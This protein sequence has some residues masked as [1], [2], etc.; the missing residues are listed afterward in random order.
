LVVDGESDVVL[1]ASIRQ[2]ASSKAMAD[3][4]TA[5]GIGLNLVQIVTLSINLA[6]RIW[7]FTDARSAL[8]QHLETIKQR[9]DI[10]SFTLKDI[11]T[12]GFSEEAVQ[13]LT[14]FLESIDKKLQ[15]FQKML[16]EYLPETGASTMERLKKGFASLGKDSRVKEFADELSGDVDHL[17]LFLM[18]Q[19]INQPKSNLTG[20]LGGHSI[21]QVARRGVAKFVG[22]EDHMAALDTALNE[23]PH[24]AMLQ[25]MGGQG[26]TQIALEYCRRSRVAKGYRAIFWANASSEAALRE[27]FE[28]F[29]DVLK[30][31]DDNSLVD[32]DARV[33][34]T[35]RV[36][37]DWPAPWLLVLDNFDDPSKFS[38]RNYMPVSMQ[39]RI[40]ITTRAREVGKLGTHIPVAGMSDWEALDLL[41]SSGGLDRSDE[42]NIV[43]GAKIVNRLGNMPLAIDLA[44]SYLSNRAGMV[45]IN[46]FLDR[47][48]KQAEA[49][50]QVVPGV[51][52]YANDLK[53]SDTS[54]FATWELTANLL[55]PDT[56]RGGQMLTF[57]NILGFFNCESIS[58]D[59]FRT[60]HSKKRGTDEL[61]PWFSLFTD[62]SGDWSSTA[63][64]DLVAHLGSI[65][66]VEK[67]GRN[68]AGLVQ[69]S[70]HP[71]IS[72]WLRI[73]QTRDVESRARGLENHQLSA[74]MLA[75]CLSATYLE[76][77]LQPAFKMPFKE[78]NALT[79][80]L[81][82]R[83]GL[84]DVFRAR[85]QQPMFLDA[86]EPIQCVELI[87]VMYFYDIGVPSGLPIAER[88]WRDCS[89]INEQH[90]AVK[91]AAGAYIWHNLCTVLNHTEAEK[92]SREMADFWARTLGPTHPFTLEAL[93]YAAASLS[94][95]GAM[96]EAEKIYRDIVQHESDEWRQLC[97]DNVWF[98]RLEWS[99]VEL[100][101]VLGAQRSEAKKAEAAIITKQVLERRVLDGP[102]V[103]HG[104]TEWAWRCY[105]MMVKTCT[106]EGSGIALELLTR[107]ERAWGRM[108]GNYFLA[109]I[110]VMEALLD[111]ESP[112]AQERIL[113][114]LLQ[115]AEQT[116]DQQSAQGYRFLL[117]GLQSLSRMLLD[118]NR[119]EDAE[120]TLRQMLAVYEDLP[121]VQSARNAVLADL[122]RC[123]HRQGR[124][125]AADEVLAQIVSP[126]LD[127][128]ILHSLVKFKIGLT[129][130]LDEASV[131][132]DKALEYFLIPPEEPSEDE[133]AGGGSFSLEM[134][135]T[136]AEDSALGD[137]HKPKY[138]LDVNGSVSIEVLV[139]RGL[140]RLRLGD[141]PGGH[142]NLKE[143]EDVF[144]EGGT[145][146][147][148]L[149]SEFCAFIADR[150]QELIDFLQSPDGAPLVDE[151]TDKLVSLLDWAIERAAT[152]HVPEDRK[153]ELL[154][155]LHL[156]RQEIQD[157]A[158]LLVVTNDNLSSLTLVGSGSSNEKKTKLARFA[159]AFLNSAKNA[160]NNNNNKPASFESDAVTLIPSRTSTIKVPPVSLSSQLSSPEKEEPS[161]R[162]KSVDASL[163]EP[164]YH[165]PG[166]MPSS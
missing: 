139:L 20:H 25:G 153:E 123:L 57:L 65:S 85:Q 120:R 133:G 74:K 46:D 27:S 40:I 28:S 16:D 32:A 30:A 29:S 146:A 129:E 75:A 143:A 13:S 56:E 104:S 148:G 83:E 144:S 43:Q 110:T 115:S 76:F 90:R 86:S 107:I 82:T 121:D 48:S 91:R 96:D 102:L 77:L 41:L 24:V 8:P 118:R 155:R 99:L 34:F 18:T 116:G 122:G 113:K 84:D 147:D 49:V 17:T 149:T 33:A 106:K 81:L 52:E 92:K 95:L 66:L 135:L 161:T 98:P 126:G 15:R 60:Y 125:G 19:S 114:H 164:H 158:R 101:Y 150:V 10:V 36:L 97:R 109:Q 61:P 9:L 112:A 23:S 134:M 31:P 42:N 68:D 138:K 140:C 62:D 54:V 105:G 47:Y 79:G 162:T 45:K 145:A 119:L 165:V 72:D 1:I 14:Q 64:E 151:A 141:V 38:I 89:V 4:F 159:K 142:G 71:L 128:L 3:P 132:L 94:Y 93:Y 117:W 160:G 5:I 80:H 12:S 156:L 124:A 163:D 55:Q 130:K 2:F 7:K 87:F 59:L 111:R 103:R 152:E 22:R 137:S 69:F 100:V 44:G 136:G 35:K 21:Y 51:S 131:L 73:R 37:T 157:L 53:Q 70:I 78:Q 6:N 127:S 26:K 88:L 39:G 63:F 67:P 154:R 166:E 50:L 58:E 11:D 108:H